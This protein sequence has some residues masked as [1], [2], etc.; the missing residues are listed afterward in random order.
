MMLGDRRHIV[1]APGVYPTSIR[2]SV[3]GLSIHGG[4]ATITSIINNTRSMF[5]ITMPTLIRNL[6]FA[7]ARS[8]TSS[9]NVLTSGVVTV[10]DAT[11]SAVSR[12]LVQGVATLRNVVISDAPSPIG[13]IEV[14]AG[15]ELT[16]DR[17]RIVRGVVGIRAAAGAEVHVSNVLI[18]GTSERALELASA[19]GDV[20]FTT[21]A[22][23]GLSS[24]ME[25]PCAMTCNQNVRVSNSI[26]WQQTCGGV[27]RDAAGACSFTSS[28]VSNAPAPGVMNVDPRFQDPSGNDFHLGATSPARDALDIGPAVDFEGDGRPVNGRFDIGADEAL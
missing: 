27:V 20:E 23:V 21:V 22:N 16:F 26:I 2:L 14:A 7:E 6:T 17:G 1:M 10:E 5:E 25:A 12:V 24:A 11:F 4:G 15:A 8:T 18:H 3:N 9:I 19:T 28:I 13:A